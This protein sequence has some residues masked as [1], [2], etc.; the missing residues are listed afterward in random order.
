M[1]KEVT[2]SWACEAHSGKSVYHCKIY[3]CNSSFQ[4]SKQEKLSV[5]LNILDKIYWEKQ[6]IVE[7]QSGQ[8]KGW[9]SEDLVIFLSRRMEAP[10]L[11]SHTLT[12]ALYKEFW[13]LRWRDF[14]IYALKII[15]ESCQRKR[16]E[17]LCAKI[18]DLWKS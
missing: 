9:S 11:I 13:Y 2:I 17:L 12:L 18:T 8:N 3:Q 1:L 7:L 10:S 4:Q 16:L 15:L 14:E 5:N 6:R